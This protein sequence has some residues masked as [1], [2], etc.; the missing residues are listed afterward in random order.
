MQALDVRLGQLHQ[1]AERPDL[2]TVRMAG[3]LQPDAVL[4]GT[5]DLFGLM[6]QQHQLAIGIATVNGRCQVRAVT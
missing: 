5:L 4:S 1:E 6:R 3:E 2:A